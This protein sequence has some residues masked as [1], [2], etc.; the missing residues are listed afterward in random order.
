MPTRI[1]PL[2]NWWRCCIPAAICNSALSFKLLLC[3]KMCLRRI[4][5]WE[6][7]LL[8][9]ITFV[10]ES[11]W[12]NM[13]Y[14]CWHMSMTKRCVLFWNSTPICLTLQQLSACWGIS[15]VYWNGWFPGRPKA[16]HEF[17]L[18]TETERQQILLEWNDTATDYPREKCIHQLFEEQV[19]LVPD[20]CAVIFGQQQLT[21]REVNQRAN[22]IAHYLQKQGAGPEIPVGLYLDRSAGSVNCHFG[23][24]QGRQ[25]LCAYGYPLP[26]RASN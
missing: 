6:N 4:F 7:A 24:P 11:V 9:M 15:S 12:Q 22:Q 14:P 8:S 17:D 13:I 19:E 1:Y 20:N 3:L 25:S 2:K 10:V 26:G 18:L 23:Y 16:Y 21:Y 5:V